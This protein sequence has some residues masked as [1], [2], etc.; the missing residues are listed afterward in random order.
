MGGT[1]PL[2]P[3]RDL[4]RRLVPGG[5]LAVIVSAALL[6]AACG[7]D[8]APR[9]D[10]EEVRD[11]LVDFFHDAA[12]GDI[13]AVCAALTGAGR[14]Q[15]AGRGSITGRLPDPASEQRCIEKR[16]QAATSSVDLPVVIRRRL[17]RVQHV[18]IDGNAARARVCNAAL[19]RERRLRKTEG[20]WRIES[21]Q[22]PVND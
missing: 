10:R 1:L 11:V 13:E 19:C 2:M 14:A 9:P 21:F 5:V 15:A 7:E 16:A 20:G 18:R 6:V 12:D 3:A 8:D 4:G 17:L 22:L